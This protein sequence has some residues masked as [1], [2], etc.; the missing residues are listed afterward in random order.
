MSF[1]RSVGAVVFRREKKKNTYLLLKRAPVIKYPK[2]YIA[3]GDYW[4]LPKG[5]IKKG[6]TQLETI[7]RE[8]KEEAG[9]GRVKNI[10]GFFTWTSFFYR[11]KGEEKKNRKKKKK[12]LNIFKVVTYYIF[13]TKTKRIILS[14]E[15]IDYKWLEYKKAYEL[16][17]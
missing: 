7:K 13:E 12:G 5:R 11:A 8:I 10:S 1:E 2:G 15:H 4:D 17:T 6:E 3:K 16:L 14:R 9:I